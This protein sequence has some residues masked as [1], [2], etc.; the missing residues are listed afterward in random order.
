MCVV[1]LSKGSLTCADKYSMSCRY[2]MPVHLHN[3]LPVYVKKGAPSIYG[4]SDERGELAIMKRE[5]E[6]NVKVRD[7][8]KELLVEM[9]KG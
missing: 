9:S 1:S 2:D 8:V 4:P 6:E 7:E 5:Y 3:Y